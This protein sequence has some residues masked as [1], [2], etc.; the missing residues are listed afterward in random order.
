MRYLTLSKSGTWYF[1]YQLPSQY[2]QLFN[3]RVEIK[4]S[5]KT[6]SKS[7][8]KILALELELDIRRTLATGF[9]TM[10]KQAALLTPS[11]KIHVLRK[12]KQSC[13]YLALDKFYRYKSD[14]IS[15]KTADSLNAKCRT[16]LEL[17]GKK[18][19]EKI[20]R[21]EAE[22]VKQKLALVPTN[23]RKHGEFNSLSI[24]E[25]I[26]LNA[27]LKKDTLSE[28]SVKNY[29]HSTSSFFEWCVLNELTDVN[30]FKAIRFRKNTRD[31][32]AK[33]AYT[34]NELIKIFSHP[35]FTNSK[36]LHPH[37]YWLPLL[38]KFTGA[39]LNELCQLYRDNIICIQNIWCISIEAS[40]PDQKL[41][42]SQSRR[43]IPIHDELIS[44]GFIQYT[45]SLNS[46][47]LFPELKNSRD[48]YGSAPSKW[49]SRF[50]TKLGF[51]KGHDFH[52]IRHTVATEL[53]N[54]LVSSEVASA[55]LGHLSNNITYDRY[56]KGFHLS[57]LRDAINKIPTKAV[58]NVKKFCSLT[59]PCV[60]PVH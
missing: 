34:P 9:K 51:D 37:Y 29:I 42:N 14:H 1:R 57:V 28:E 49:F 19:I 58:I 54:E 21:N 7:Q 30:P 60:S 31:C 16:V 59:T 22:A 18:S 50:K 47:Q 4:R 55:L 24:C 3:G 35:I 39:R 10:P 45:N 8:A 44:L 12:P 11:P 26:T 43:L 40:R 27:K 17:I 46:D 36:S 32:D 25:A 13:P 2:R 6:S 52:S 5:L 56:G 33:N 53:K 15:L 48:G 41:K 20:R 38:A 23:I